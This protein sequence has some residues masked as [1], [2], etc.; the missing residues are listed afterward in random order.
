M[1]IT[2][3]RGQTAMAKDE[4]WGMVLDA[5]Q[6]IRQRLDGHIDDEDDAIEKVR[7]EIADVKNEMSGHRVK[8]SLILTAFGL[9]LT[10]IISWVVNNG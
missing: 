3:D 5:L 9:I 1:P 10:G 4:R 2:D 6:Y 8:I 7:T